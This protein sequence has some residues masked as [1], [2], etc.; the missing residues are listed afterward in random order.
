MS[1]ITDYTPYDDTEVKDKITTLETKSNTLEGIVNEL[2]SQIL[3]SVYPVGSIYTSMSETNPNTL[4]GFGTWERIT[5]CF[6]YCTALTTGRT[7]GSL[8][9]KEGNLPKHSHVLNGY[10]WDWGTT[11]ANEN[12]AF[13]GVNF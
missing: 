8:K 5:N 2:K 9:I 12:W 11:T 10:T 6:L 7:G 1:D 3:E 13:C 4:F